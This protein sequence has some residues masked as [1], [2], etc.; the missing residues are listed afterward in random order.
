MTTRAGIGFLLLVSLCFGGSFWG[1]VATRTLPAPTVQPARVVSCPLAR[2]LELDAQ[3]AAAIDSRDPQFAEDLKVLRSA[4]GEARTALAAAFEREDAAAADIREHVEDTI[5]AHNRLER[6][7]AEYLI[8][9]RD[10]LTVEQQARLLG[11]CAKS[12]RECGR[13]WDGGKDDTACSDCTACNTCALRKPQKRD[14]TSGA[15]DSGG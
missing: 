15:G 7:V 11:F 3:Q 8:A 4:L 10:H 13:R 9:V 14:Q 6:R 5:Q 1:T 2:E 12:V